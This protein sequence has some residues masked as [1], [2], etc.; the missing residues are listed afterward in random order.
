MKLIGSLQ[1]PC[2][3]HKITAV[4]DGKV[5]KCKTCKQKWTTTTPL[6]SAHLQ[7]MLREEVRTVVFVSLS[8]NQASLMDIQTDTS[9]DVA[10]PVVETPKST[11]R[12]GVAR[13][14]IPLRKR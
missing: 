14:Y 1:L 10:V 5:V 13:G 9:E 6:A 3:H 11:R 7:E 2:G 4:E 12:K 8:S